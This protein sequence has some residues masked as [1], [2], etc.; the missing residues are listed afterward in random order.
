MPYRLVAGPLLRLS[1]VG[2][3]AGGGAATGVGSTSQE[4]RRRFLVLYEIVAGEGSDRPPPPD[5]GESIVH[6]SFFLRL[7]GTGS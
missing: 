4:E 7:W 2:N 5:R 6:L 3:G 1:A